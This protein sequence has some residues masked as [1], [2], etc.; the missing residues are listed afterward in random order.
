MMAKKKLKP[1]PEPVQ[2]E[3]K[4]DLQAVRERVFGEWVT[5]KYGNLDLVAWDRYQEWLHHRLKGGID[6]AQAHDRV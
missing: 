1:E 2:E 4:T 5:E 3:T 6:A